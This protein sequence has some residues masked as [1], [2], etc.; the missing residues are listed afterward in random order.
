M[1]VKSGPRRWPIRA[2]IMAMG[3][4]LAL[5]ISLFQPGCRDFAAFET[6]SE[7]TPVVE[8][9]A[10]QPEA[11]DQVSGPVPLPSPPPSSPPASPASSVEQPAKSEPLPAQ[12]VREEAGE[13]GGAVSSSAGLVTITSDPPD[14]TIVVD[15]KRLGNSP[16]TV[17]LADGVHVLEVKKQGYKPYR[18]VL[19]VLENSELRLRVKLEPH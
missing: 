10:T 1:T 4:C 13:N 3:F 11:R 14:C 5:V 15:D 18:R 16:A 8:P 9:P 17:S 7:P 2:L 19:R 12:P 6:R